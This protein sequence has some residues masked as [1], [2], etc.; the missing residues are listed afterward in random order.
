MLFCMQLCGVL[1]PSSLLE[2]N[3]NVAA[4]DWSISRPSAPPH[5]AA[6]GCCSELKLEE[7]LMFNNAG[8]ENKCDDLVV[9][10]TSEAEEMVG[11]ALTCFSHQSGSHQMID[12]LSED[13]E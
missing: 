8:K 13:K 12:S 6:V 2:L 5:Q 11:A 3:L 4:G 9:Q 1:T 7:K 10:Q